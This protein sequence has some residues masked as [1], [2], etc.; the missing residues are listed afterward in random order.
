MSALDC[1]PV[2]TLGS[3]TPATSRTVPEIVEGPLLPTNFPQSIH[4][5]LSWVGRKREDGTSCIVDTTEVSKQEL[6]STLK[7][8]KRTVV[9]ASPFL[10]TIYTTSTSNAPTME[11]SELPANFPKFLDSLLSWSGGKYE[12]DDS[13]MLALDDEDKAELEQALKHFKCK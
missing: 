8:I 12:S 1:G 2:T 10:C 7:H 11:L 4:S 6:E 13:Y 5:P 9:S 3:F